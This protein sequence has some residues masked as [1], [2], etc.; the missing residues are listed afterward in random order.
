MAMGM[1]DERR[2]ATVGA[3]AIEVT[4]PLHSMIDSQWKIQ[5]LGLQAERLAAEV[6]TVRLARCR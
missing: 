5:N 3:A 6:P 2:E 4:D 1:A